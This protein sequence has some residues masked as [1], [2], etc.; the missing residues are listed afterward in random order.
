MPVMLIMSGQLQMVLF[1]ATGTVFERSSIGIIV[2]ITLE[3]IRS[4]DGAVGIII[5]AFQ[6]VFE[7]VVVKPQA[8]I[9][10]GIKC[11]IGQEVK[12]FFVPVRPLP[13]ARPFQQRVAGI[14][15]CIQR[16]PFFTLLVDIAEYIFLSGRGRIANTDIQLCVIAIGIVSSSAILIFYRIKIS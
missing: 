9:A 4:G 5:I 7:P 10:A 16:C 3:C 14:R 2:V 12:A 8:Y 11:G 13:V 15:S 1:D 6:Q